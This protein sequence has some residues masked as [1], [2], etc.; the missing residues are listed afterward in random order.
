MLDNFWESSLKSEL[1]G[2][3]RNVKNIMVAGCL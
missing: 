2:E 3:R 1:G